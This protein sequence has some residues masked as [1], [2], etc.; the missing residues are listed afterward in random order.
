MKKITFLI[1]W[2]QPEDRN[3]DGSPRSLSVRPG[4]SDAKG[5]GLIFGTFSDT[6]ISHIEILLSH[7]P[8][9][10]FVSVKPLS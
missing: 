2:K 9:R 3:C 7:D 1:K 5:N 6:G 10:I 4:A 8:Q